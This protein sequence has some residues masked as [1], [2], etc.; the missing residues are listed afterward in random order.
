MWKTQSPKFVGK[1]RKTPDILDEWYGYQEFFSH[2]LALEMWT[3][4]LRL[5]TVIS[6][7][8]TVVK[9]PFWMDVQWPTKNI[10]DKI[11]RGILLLLSILSSAYY[12]SYA[13]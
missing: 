6:Q 10:R 12:M 2:S 9:C 4:Y 3:Q 1:Y 8:K 11:A 13:P 5:Q 7:K